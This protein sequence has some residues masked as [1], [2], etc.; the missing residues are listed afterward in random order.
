MFLIKN[1]HGVYYT[2]MPLP[3]LLRDQDLQF[4]I[5]ASLQTK[6]RKVAISR[7]LAMAPICVN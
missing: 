5:R 3:K 4:C 7:N 1:P 6:E 2:R